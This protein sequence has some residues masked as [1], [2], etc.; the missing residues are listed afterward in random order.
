MEDGCATA[1]AAPHAVSRAVA[2]RLH[3]DMTVFCLGPHG[4]PALP[5]VLPPFEFLLP[6]PCKSKAKNG[7]LNYTVLSG[8]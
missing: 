2:R 1:R 4:S 6:L 5:P 8:K 7:H 3:R